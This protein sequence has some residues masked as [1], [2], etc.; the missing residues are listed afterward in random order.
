MQ[1]QC[2]EKERKTCTVKHVTTRPTWS[3]CTVQ[4]VP[5]QDPYCRS[6]RNA[7]TDTEHC[8]NNDKTTSKLACSGDTEHRSCYWTDK[9]NQQC[10]LTRSVYHDP[11]TQHI[12]IKSIS[13]FSETRHIYWN[14][15][16]L[17]TSIP[18][19]SPHSCHQSSHVLIIII[20]KCSKRGPI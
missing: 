17:S 4:I 7:A 5:S 2:P 19:P 10:S 3:Q 9:K 11:V 18:C 8:E 6:Q 16:R 20:G 13:A 1:H 14:F 12:K 15:S